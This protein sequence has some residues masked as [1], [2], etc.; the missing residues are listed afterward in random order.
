MLDFNQ[1]EILITGG[2]GFF[3]SFLTEEMLKR[4]ARVTLFDRFYQGTGRI[5]HLLNH[6]AVK[7]VEADLSEYDKLVEAVRGKYLIWHLAGNTNIPAGLQDTFLDLKDGV[8][9]TR[10][11]L[12]AMRETA[13]R[14]LIFP[15]SGAIYGEKTS[16]FRSESA[17]PTLPISL[18]GAGKLSCEAF[19]SAY[20]HLFGLQAWIFRYGNI[21]SGRISHGVIL[22]FIRKLRANPNELEVLG[23]G[24]QAKSYLLAEECIDG[25]LHV[26]SKTLPRENES[27]CDVFNLGAPDET[28]VLDIARIATEEMGLK[29]CKIKL[30]GGERGWPGDQAR[31]ALD[32]SKI[33]SLGWQP[34]HSSNDAVRISIRRMLEQKDLFVMPA[35]APQKVC[36]IGLWHLGL[37]SAACLADRGCD[38]TGY[39]KNKKIVAELNQGKLPLFEPGLEELVKAG[40]S[41]G[42]LRFED[43][44]AKAVTSARTVLL[45]Y[46]TPVDDDDQVDLSILE[47]SLEA[48]L[49]YMDTEALLVIN[50]QIPVR[51][52]EKWQARIQAARPESSIDLV[53]SPENLRLGQ[54]IENFKRPD[55]I[56]IGV[57]SERARKKAEKFFESFHTEK[58]FVSWRTAE[59]AKHA[60]NGF[61]ATSIS[62]ANEFGRLCDAAGADGIEISK[63]LKKDSR[64]GKKAQVRPG[65]GFAG[66]TLARD[67]RALQKLGRDFQIPTPL[68][69][70]VLEINRRQTERMIEMLEEC[71]EGNLRGKTFAVFGLT[72]KPGTS[73]LRRSASLEIIGKLMAKG[74][75]IQAHDPKA[76]LGEYPGKIPFEFCADPYKAAKGS[77]AI[78]MM[79]E[80]P[81]YR[82]LD[83]AKIFKAVRRPV[84]L[85][86]KN[87]LESAKLREIGF[88][89]LEIGRGQLAGVKA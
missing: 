40:M 8:I 61:F 71:F 87:H 77:D 20:S 32:G 69:D 56:V 25:M 12:E 74:A 28:P 63:I 26:I 36:V 44:A 85:D 83:Y 58:F 88:I 3:G 66:A 86:A 46:D 22:D 39:D 59:M 42:R 54:A 6:P 13:V 79:T 81:E 17:G 84:I 57:N 55:M 48:V 68:F 60:L 45:T 29:N 70:S 18:Y 78:L 33:R 7:I 37:T 1:K 16:G 5:R 80:G 41:K 53:Y 10:N 75:R 76:D 24:T 38:V 43:S 89:H 51:T 30:K 21:I 52:S 15:S 9:A 49:P 82:A 35:A 64:I 62:F 14:R 2:A 4:G 47:K 73:T 34:K 72:Y 50:S 23:D 67:L 27:F 11:I 31:I 65:L 19:I